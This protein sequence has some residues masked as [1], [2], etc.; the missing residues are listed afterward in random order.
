MNY[1]I[2]PKMTK[3]KSKVGLL[4]RKNIDL[5]NKYLHVKTIAEACEICASKTLKLHCKI[6]C[7]NCGFIR[8]CS[9]P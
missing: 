4:K 6:I 2:L 8:D 5:E 1:M 3:A 9:D 7:Y